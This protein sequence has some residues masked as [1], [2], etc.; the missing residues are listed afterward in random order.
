MTLRHDLIQI[1]DG[2]WYTRDA[3][4]WDRPDTSRPKKYHVAVDGQAA[5]GSRVVLDGYS[6]VRT[7]DECLVCKRC[8]RV[9][10]ANAAG[11]E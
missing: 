6:A 5:C 11:G 4:W 8:K 9:L 10:A 7:P 1:H 3:S 2:W